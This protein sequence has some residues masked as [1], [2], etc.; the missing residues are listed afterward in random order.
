MKRLA[1]AL[2]ALAM[3][4]GGPERPLEASFEQERCLGSLIWFEARGEPL[5]AQRAVLDVA[6]ARAVQ[7]GT[8]ACDVI[9]KPGQFTWYDGR[10]KLYDPE[11]QALYAK[12]RAEKRSLKFETFFFSGGPPYWAAGMK[13]RK[14]G[15]LNFCKELRK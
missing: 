5:K 6:L 15:R 13:C 8:S 4:L 12:A 14:I 7:S 3:P 9:A 11:L 10:L 1:A 2:L